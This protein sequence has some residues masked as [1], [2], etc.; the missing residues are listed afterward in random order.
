MRRVQ[1]NAQAFEHLS[2]GPVLFVAER[3]RVL[4]IRVA[5]AA[6]TTMLWGLLEL[7]G[8]D[9]A[10]MN[11]SLMPLLSTPD[12]LVHD[13]GLYP[14]PTLADVSPDL[15]DVAL[16]SPGWLRVAVVRNPY[17][18]LYSAWESKVLLR[19]AD[20]SRFRGAPKLIENEKGVDVG[21]S[22]RSFVFAL[23]ERPERWMSDRHF[24][25]QVDL[26]PRAVIN[27]IELVPTAAIPDLFGRLSDRAGMVVTPR[28]SNE[29]LGI[30]GS[31]LLDD[32]TAERIARL[33]ASDFELTGTDPTAFTPSEPVFLDSVAVCLLR[34]AAARSER[35]VQLNRS[36]QQTP[37][38]RMGKLVRRVAHRLSKH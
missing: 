22:F 32:E 14:V 11:R 15:R 20:N 7:E 23:S 18:R 28:Q 13:P 17:A 3:S 6:C 9:P 30:D 5:K 37:E 19:L 12:V 31:A 29:G 4:Y 8:H 27:D 16:T 25:R 38:Q 33:Y 10:M 34:L 36:Y 21:A 1:G 26:V 35:A 2:D 24:S